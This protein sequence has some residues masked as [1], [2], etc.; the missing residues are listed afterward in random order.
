M[1]WSWNLA[2]KSL[3]WQRK[4]LRLGKIRRL[5]KWEYWPGSV[6]YFPIVL[7]N[8]FYLSLRYRGITT[9]TASNPAIEDGG[10]INE[11]KVA[12]LKL[13][14]QANPQVVPKF[15]ELSVDLSL[16]Q[17]QETVQLALN[18][19]VLSFPCVF[20]PNAGQRG[21]GVKVVYDQPS[22]FKYLTQMKS[23]HILQEYCS[24][25]EV[26]VFYCRFPKQEH[27]EIFSITLKTLPAVVGDGE[28]SLRELI[29]AH[30]R[31]VCMAEYLFTLLETRLEEIPRAGEHVTLNQIGSHCKGAMFE[32]GTRYAN[33]NL[34]KQLDVMMGE[35]TGLF[36][37]RFDIMVSSLDD[38]AQGKNFKVIEFNGVSSEATHIYDPKYNVFD[39]WRTL[40]RQWHIAYK[41]GFVQRRQ[42]HRC[43]SLLKLYREIK[44]YRTKA[45]SYIG[46]AKPTL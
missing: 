45:Q 16:E 18:E 25:S 36:Y 44:G 20:K 35:R 14:A 1:L 5:L 32:D 26:S 37:G 22:L 3:A 46:I 39:A 34:L 29:L 31:H 23:T 12:I 24:G 10:M 15:I 40:A 19:G 7:H 11:S 21:T 41:L 43:S 9:F 17:L 27:G 4:R 33:A 8:I 28:S 30:E 42:G 2:P 6:L 13:L 38:L